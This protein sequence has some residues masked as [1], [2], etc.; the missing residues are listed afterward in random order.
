MPYVNG[1][2]YRQAGQGYAAEKSKMEHGTGPKKESS[3]AEEDGHGAKGS[4]L[5]VKHH[6]GGKFSVKHEDGNVTKHEGM[7]DLH[8]HMAEHYGLNEHEPDGDEDGE[9]YAM[10]G[11][12]PLKSILG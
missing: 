12:D 5:H 8:Q 6:G 11:H 10:D 4:V 1:Q 9:D 2:H 3:P 7:E